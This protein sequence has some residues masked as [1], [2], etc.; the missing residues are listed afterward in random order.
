MNTKA[1]DRIFEAAVQLLDE[2]E[3]IDAITV[4]RI[5]ER[6]GVGIGAVNYHFQSKDN[7]LNLAVGAMMQDEAAKWLAP[8]MEQAGSPEARLR[9]LLK[10][11]SLIGMRFPHLLEIAVRYDLEQGSFGAAD[12][13]VPLL[14]ELWEG[15]RSEAD[16]RLAALQLI[17]SIQILYLHRSDVTRFTGYN[18]DDS[19]QMEQM[20]DRLIDNML[21]V[22]DSMSGVDA[23]KG[24]EK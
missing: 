14:R 12:T 8:S 15:E 18:L 3:N 2:E 11:T 21:C 24:D 22:S 17:S 20:I 6:A 5:A 23:G 13:V 16:I 1:K 4:R 19:R 10:R 9:F 7:L